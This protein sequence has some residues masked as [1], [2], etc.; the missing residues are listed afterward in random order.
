MTS[1]QGASRKDP[2][3]GN[4][5][6]SIATPPSQCRLGTGSAYMFSMLRRSLEHRHDLRYT[7]FGRSVCVRCAEI[8]P[9]AGSS[10]SAV[11]SIQFERNDSLELNDDGSI[12][13]QVTTTLGTNGVTFDAEPGP[14]S[15]STCSSMACRNRA[16][17]FS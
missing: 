10:L 12:R 4:Y 11:Q 5:P 15:C 9:E 17:S 14:G 3:H 8:A 13:V 1:R 7:D 6:P 2:A 16:L